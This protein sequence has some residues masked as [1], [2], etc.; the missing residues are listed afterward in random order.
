[1]FK[2]IWI[3]NIH[4]SHLKQVRRLYWNCLP[5]PSI[6]IGMPESI[7]NYS[8]GEWVSYNCVGVYVVEGNNHD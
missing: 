3:G 8:A 1:M 6:Y 2:K 5:I 7:G 4:V